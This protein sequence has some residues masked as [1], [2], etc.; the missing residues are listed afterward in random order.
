[1]NTTMSTK[2][3]Q[4]L[5]D[6]AEQKGLTPERMT[7]ILASGVLAD[8][9]DAGA[10]LSNRGA[11]RRALGLGP[12]EFQITVDYTLDLAAMI[13]AG[14]YDYVNPDIMAGSFPIKGEGKRELT[15]QLVHFNRVISSDDVEK[16]LSKK[17]LRPATI[18]ELLAFGA[19]FPEVQRR[20]PIIALGSVAEVRGRRSV[21]A[22]GGDRSGRN[23]YLYWR[24][25]DW[26]G[27]CRFLALPK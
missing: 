14:K 16:E 22:L 12:L 24:V 18:E 13:A 17:G 3:L 20:F 10:L 26:L 27:L 2:Q 8:V 25:S 1:M 23:L 6:L 15:A 21:S 19:T 5:L 9:L 11:V 4:S 7:V